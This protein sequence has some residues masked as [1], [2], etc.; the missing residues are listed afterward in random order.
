M[1]K[2]LRISFSLR[3]TYRVNGILYSIRQIPLI[4]KLVPQSLYGVRGI[5]I[6]ANVL[7]ILWEI[8]SGFGGKL[9]YF[10]LM[11]VGP[12]V[13]Y[14]MEANDRLFL[15]ILVF[16][17]IIGAFVNTYMFNPSRDK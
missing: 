16:L 8:V 1:I 12:C 13:L 3:N 17:T 9:L 6:A 15:H 14:R 4:G 2:T 7:S 10:L 5:K 11:L